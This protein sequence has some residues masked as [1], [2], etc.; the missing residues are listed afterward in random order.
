MQ[1]GEY[2]KRSLLGLD[3]LRRESVARSLAVPLVTLWLCATAISAPQGK[4]SENVAFDIHKVPFSRYGSYLTFQHVKGSAHIAPPDGLFLRTVHGFVPEHE[5]FRVELVQDGKA[6]PFEEIP[7]PLLLTLKSA[8]GSAE[9][10][11]ESA[12]RIRFR[13]NGVALRFATAFLPDTTTSTYALPVDRPNASAHV[14]DYNSGYEEDILLRFTCLQGSLAVENPWNG[15]KS[16]NVSFTFGEG[17]GSASEGAIEEFG[18]SYHADG[19]ARYTWPDYLYKAKLEKFPGATPLP[20]APEESFD[21][22]LSRVRGEYRSWLVGLPSVPEKYQQVAD[23][24]AYADWSA[25]VEPRGYFT[26]P[27][28][29]M[30]KATMLNLWSWDNCFNT[31]ALADAHPDLAWDQFLWVFDSANAD[32]I[33]PDF[34]NDRG[35]EWNF[36]KVP[37]QGF[38]LAY[39]ARNSPGFYNDKTRLASFYQ[40][41]GRRTE[42]FIHFRDWDH[43]GLPQ[44]NHGYDSGWDNATVFLPL[45]PVESPDL[46]AFTIL[47]LEALSHIATSLGKPEESQHW[48]SQ[49]D[50]M[51]KNML[52]KMWRGDHFVALHNGDHQVVESQSLILFLPLVLGKQLP[53]GIRNT[54]IQRLKREGDFLSNYGLASE[55]LRSRYYQRDGYWLGPMWAPSTML[56]VEAIDE[57]GEHAFADDLR[58]RY[59]NAVLKSGFAENF[60]PV[61]GEGFRDPTYTWSSSVFLIFAHELDKEQSRGTK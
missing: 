60:D 39:L 8:S 31:M 2:D 33:S 23:V 9:I 28:M 16:D 21:A 11:F 50:V 10:Y 58:Q 59:L 30:S 53:E 46:A 25:V 6:V 35:Q 57:D 20:P 56:L 36:T 15:M 1:R 7:T 38:T 48:Q 45:P 55:S 32:G 42:W 24:A 13:A 22:G 5:M 26:R 17:P 14:W 19:P 51:L 34:E 61:T 41:L 49:A 54:L 29:L 18:S 47:Q 27:A 40:Q 37:M 43:D 12:N 44:Y 4:Y 3:W 52:D